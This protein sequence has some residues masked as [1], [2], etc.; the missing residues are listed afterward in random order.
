MTGRQ[1]AVGIAK[2]VLSLPIY[3]EGRQQ[4]MGGAPVGPDTVHRKFS[5]LARRLARV[6]M[7]CRVRVGFAQTDE[8]QVYDAGIARVGTF[9]LT[10]HNNYAVSGGRSAA[11]DGGL[12]PNHTLNGVTEWDYGLTRWFEAGLYLPLYSVS[13]SGAVTY[14]GLE[15]RPLFVVPHPPS[16]RLFLRHHFLL[17]RQP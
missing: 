17:H 1:S 7:L 3:T 14:N 11:F 2:L 8:I 12:V 13:S 4:K 5:R 10:W 16:R 6:S 15:L 9:N